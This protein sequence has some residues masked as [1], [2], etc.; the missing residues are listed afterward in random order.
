MF[1]QLFGETD[2][3]R[4]NRL[5][6]QQA[7][8]TIVELVVVIIILGILAATALPRFL[9]VEENAHAASVQA[10]RGGLETGA[11]LWKAYYVANGKPLSAATDSGI[12]GAGTIYFSADGYPA[13]VTSGKDVVVANCDEVFGILLGDASVPVL[14][15]SG[16]APN[17]QDDKTTDAYDWYVTSGSSAGA[18]GTGDCEFTYAARGDTLNLSVLVYETQYGT[19]TETGP[20]ATG[21]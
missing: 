21:Y 13:S 15:A 7:G 6:K 4:N 19:I 14:D 16:E 18:S 9:S 10:V 1:K 11:A 2:R 17:A 8:F 3:E 20:S 12:T 5:A